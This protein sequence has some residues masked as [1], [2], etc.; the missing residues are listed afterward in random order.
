MNRVVRIFL[1]LAILAS[2]LSLGCATEAKAQRDVMAFTA[3]WCGPCQRNKPTI[4]QLQKQGVQIYP[5]DIDARRDLAERYRIQ[6]VPTYV[7]RENGREV[8]RTNDVQVLV[9]LRKWLCSR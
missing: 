1:I 5:V 3:S 2:P 4:A 8:K 9:G 7:I 6:A